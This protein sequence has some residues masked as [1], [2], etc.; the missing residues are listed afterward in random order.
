M[1]ESEQATQSILIAAVTKLIMSEGHKASAVEIARYCE[2]PKNQEWLDHV[3]Q[4]NNE[5]LA[6]K[7]LEYRMVLALGNMTEAQLLRGDFPK[8]SNSEVLRRVD[9]W[10]E[11]IV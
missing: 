8:I 3:T 11:A 1:T 2:P 6:N 4:L 10:H 9:V 7:G 5:W